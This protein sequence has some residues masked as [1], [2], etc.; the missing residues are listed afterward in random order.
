MF[1]AS[2]FTTVLFV[3]KNKIMENKKEERPMLCLKLGEKLLD[4]K[5]VSV[6]KKHVLVNT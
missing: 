5:Y 1:L 2:I 3:I 4:Y 6:V